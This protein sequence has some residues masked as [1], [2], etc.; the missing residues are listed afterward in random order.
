[1][2]VQSRASGLC[3]PSNAAG[4]FI[5]RMIEGG[6]ETATLDSGTMPLDFISPRQ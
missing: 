3:L 4:E 5:G 6:L 2:R 1:M